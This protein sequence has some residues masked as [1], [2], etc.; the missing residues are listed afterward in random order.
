MTLR[1][2]LEAACT[3]SGLSM[4]A[5]SVLSKARD[6]YRLDT[7][8]GHRAAQWLAEQMERLRVRTPVHLRGLF[9]VLVAAGGVRKPD[10]ELFVNN[11]HDWTWLADGAAKCA[12]WLGYVEWSAIR[13]ERNGP[14]L[15]YAYPSQPPSATVEFENFIYLPWPRIQTRVEVSELRPRQRHRLALIGEKTSLAN[16]LLPV[17]MAHDAFLY[18]PAGEASDTMIHEIAAAAA[19]DGRPTIVQYYSDADPSGHQMPI[20][21]ARKLQALRDLLFP[22]LE[23]EV[24]P[25]ALSVEQVKKF[26]LPSTPLRET[27]KRADKWKAAFGVEQTEIDALAALRPE[28]L[29][30]LADA[31]IAPYFDYSLRTRADEARQEYVAELQRLLNE[32]ESKVALDALARDAELLLKPLRKRMSEIEQRADEIIE[33]IAIEQPPIVLPEAEVHGKPCTEAIYSSDWDW[34]EATQR[35]RERKAYV[36]GEE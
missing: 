12:R 26:D 23:I 4:R 28:L 29:R 32:H 10:G 31:A 34:T 19:A 30:R 21:V 9:Y 25:V 27:E 22:E 5:L 24:H 14:P 33:E 16:V 18:L 6:P 7:E 13:D 36:N 3:E 17:A 8:A 2:R 11:D 20:S 15:A 35:L 1:E